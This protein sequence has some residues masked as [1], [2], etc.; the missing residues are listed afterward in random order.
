VVTDNK[1]PTGGISTKKVMFGK[2][3]EETESSEEDQSVEETL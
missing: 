2:K 3:H 1:S